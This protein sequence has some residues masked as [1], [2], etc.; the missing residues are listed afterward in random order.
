MQGFHIKKSSAWVSLKTESK[1]GIRRVP[2][3]RGKNPN[4]ISGEN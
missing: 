4:V 1:V 2:I 3:F